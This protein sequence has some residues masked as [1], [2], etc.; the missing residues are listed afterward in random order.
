MTT[1]K[2]KTRDEIQ[3]ERRNTAGHSE[4]VNPYNP[5]NLRRPTKRETAAALR[6]AIR[7]I[8]DIEGAG[9]PYEDDPGVGFPAPKSIQREQIMRFRGRRGPIEIEMRVKANIDRLGYLVEETPLVVALHVTVDGKAVSGNEDWLAPSVIWQ[10]KHQWANTEDV[11]RDIYDLA[12]HMTSVMRDTVSV[13][14]IGLG[15]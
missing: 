14:D 3:V 11:R 7:E 6:N 9:S 13:T 10:A 5:D 2:T 15:E 1:T 8:S 4:W 12:A